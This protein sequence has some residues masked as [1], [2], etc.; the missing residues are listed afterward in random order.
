MNRNKNR[1]QNKY[2][3]RAESV[4][5]WRDKKAVNEEINNNDNDQKRHY[6][7]FNKNKNF[8]K[9]FERNEESQQRRNYNSFNRNR[10]DDHQ[11][12]N[13]YNSF[14]RNRNDDGQRQNNYNSFNSNRNYDRNNRYNRNNYNYD[15]HYQVKKEVQK[16]YNILDYPELAYNQADNEKTIVPDYLKMCKKT[17]QEDEERKP[18][19]NVNDPKYWDRHRYIG[20]K[21]MKSDKQSSPV[22]QE[23]LREASKNASSIVIPNSKI[24][25]SR[26]GLNW[27]P[28]WKE[29]FTNEEWNNMNAQIEQDS[30]M[31]I[32]DNLSARYDKE[33][34]NA[35]KLYDE[36]GEVN[37][38]LQC[39]LDSIEHDKYLEQLNKQYEEV[40]LFEESDDDSEYDY[41]SN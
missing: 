19:V 4:S 22:F 6:S 20:P 32:F 8:D 7:T 14:N 2:S 33:L 24:M 29:T 3:S 35:Y 25:Y 28:S 10:K 26:D 31:R 38:C 30:V 37:G 40:Y 13:N 12:Q 1:Y 27:Y 34:Q 5:N 15:H 18:V 39:H 36:T 21:L 17:K 9:N 11:R 41:Y 23:Y 16:E